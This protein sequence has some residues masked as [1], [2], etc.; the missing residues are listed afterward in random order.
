VRSRN[1]GFRGFLRIAFRERPILC[2]GIRGNA[3]GAQDARHRSLVAT[4]AQ[5]RTGETP[6][7]HNALFSLRTVSRARGSAHELKVACVAAPR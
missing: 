1:N 6:A 3:A 4:F 7:G 5:R 2:H